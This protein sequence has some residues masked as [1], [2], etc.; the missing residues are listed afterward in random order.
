MYN[1]E[2]IENENIKQKKT[3]SLLNGVSKCVFRREQYT[4]INAQPSYYVKSLYLAS[5]RSQSQ[6]MIVFFMLLHNVT[7]TSGARQ[8]LGVI[9]TN[10]TQTYKRRRRK[11]NTTE[12]PFCDSTVTG[13][14]CSFA[15]DACCRIR[16]RL[17]IQTSAQF[18]VC[19][20][21]PNSHGK[22]AARAESEI[23][24]VERCGANDASM[25]QRLLK[26]DMQSRLEASK[27]SSD[28]LSPRDLCIPA[29]VHKS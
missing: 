3:Y 22:H 16:R 2:R 4:R 29:V 18:N 6:D 23:E 11:W 15:V 7:F 21:Q 9:G 24:N 26:R 13:A 19:K 20:R 5:E 10:G 27:F 14:C 1:R 12:P 17:N 8:G 25:T 28:T